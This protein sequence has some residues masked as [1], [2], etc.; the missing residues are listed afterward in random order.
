MGLMGLGPGQTII[1]LGS[2]TIMI[3]SASVS[4]RSLAVTG[5]P[6]LML[7][8]ANLLHWDGVPVVHGIRER[9]RWAVGSSRA[10]TVYRGGVMAAGEHAWQLP[11]VLAP[12]TLLTVKDPL[13]GDFGVV[14][15][16]RLGT[17]TATLRCAATSTWLADADAAEAWVSNWGSWLASLGHH[18][19]VQFVST[20]VDSAPDSGSRLAD[21]VASRQA[22][23]AP[24]SAR[25]V[26]QQLVEAAPAASADV[27][28]RVSITFRPAAAPTRPRT[29]E[30]ALSEIARQLPG[31]QD[32]LA[33]CGVTVLS[34]ATAA[35]LMATVR[36]AYDPTLRGAVAQ[37]VGRY[38]GPELERFLDWDTCGPIAA[39]EARGHYVHDSATSVSWAW[40]EAPRQP[41]HSD[42]L[43]RLMAPG[44]FP[45]RV[46]LIYRPL[47]AGDAARIVEKEVN[48]AA[49]RSAYKRAQRRDE[50]A[51]DL[52]D[53]ELA[54]RNA[55]EEATG[56]GVGLLT[57]FI[58]VT[59]L[60]D[61][62]L[63]RAIADIESRA[64]A[65]KI[66]LRRLWASQAAGFATTLPCGVCPPILATHWPR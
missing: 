60:D 48:A 17:M 50:S 19:I 46:S 8:G 52:A 49:F 33:S 15:N 56:A 18:P 45:K 65:A 20:T 7:I 22:P 25:K 35:D 14:Y 53:R 58:T 21:Y 57:L 55:L 47:P 30:E 61:E 59:V 34:R 12:T 10:R 66:R 27:E 6:A 38:S 31:L 36:A 24:P 3:I 1:V 64:D 43:A 11:G 29:V 32:G 41:V 51:R 63:G 5:P 26:L 4:L 16:R 28:T 62:D 13:G 40:H 39:D 23:H 9:L 44:P 54:M 37:L 2:V 42:V